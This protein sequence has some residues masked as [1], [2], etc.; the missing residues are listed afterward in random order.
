MPDTPYAEL[1]ASDVKANLLLVDDQES[2][3]LALESI[4]EE[5]GQNLVRARS[6]EEA[7]RRLLQDDYAAIL[8]DVQMPGLDGYETAQLIRSRRKSRHTPIIF[9]TAH[10]SN[11]LS[12]EQAYSLGAVDYLIKPLVPTIL[13]SKVNGFI[14][15]YRKTELVRRQAELIQENERRAASEAL[16]SSEARKSAILQAALDAIITIDAEG[17]IVEFNPAAETLFGYPRS[18]ALGRDLADLVIPS[19]LRERHRRGIARY[20]ASGEGPILNKRLEMP[21][22]RADGSELWVELAITPIDG[23]RQRLF[24][25]FLRDISERRASETALREHA[26]LASLRADAGAAFASGK[27]LRSVLQQCVEAIVHHLGAAFARVWT[28][29]ETG[30]MLLLQASAGLYTHLDGPHS[31]VKVGEFKIGRIA[32]QRQPHLTNAVAEDPWVSDPAWA[33]LEGMTA[34]AGYP[35]LAEGRLLGVLALFSRERLSER[36]LTDLAP[37]VG[38]LAQYIELRRSH[39]ELESRVR[40]RTADLASANAALQRE[41]RERREAEE[42]AKEFAAELQRSNQ[43]LEQFASVASHDLQEPLRKIQAF[44]DRLQARCAEALDEQGNDYLQR[45]RSAAARMRTLIDD[46]LTFSRVTTRGQPFVEVDLAVEAEQVVSDLESR[47]QQ[48]GGRVEI[49]PLPR[50]R[51]DPTQMRQLLQNLLVN[52][53]KFHRPNEP[54]VVRLEGRLLP[55]GQPDGASLWEIVVRDNGIGFEEKYLDRIFQLFQRLHG[56][57]EY[58]GTGLGLAIC[59]KIV[60]RHGGTIAARSTPGQGATFFVTLPVHPANQ[61]ERTS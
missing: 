30:E 18:A 31:R 10:D 28:L 3:L 35:M 14:E 16:H 9:L 25:G 6:G 15:L 54:P 7:L 49:G 41:V 44:G 42:R 45:M 52:A 43:E 39:E 51:A 53:L 47:L 38:N 13:R 5:L 12:I 1:Q 50:L 21:G 46:L 34:F 19:A 20:L 36:V 22:R 55:D 29:D 57:G 37:V 56:R 32:Q 59:R 61:E 40:A 48:T 58:E 8:L 4:L 2:N 11:R 26:R 27:D 24:T 60:E 23:G 17:R 33:K